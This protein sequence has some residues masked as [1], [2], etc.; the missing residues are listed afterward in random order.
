VLEW[1]TRLTND[2]QG[3]GADLEGGGLVLLAGD[4][5]AEEH[6][7]AEA[8]DETGTILARTHLPDGLAGM[9]AFQELLGRNA[10]PRWPTRTR[11]RLPVGVRARVYH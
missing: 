9:A 6:Y 7:D 8:Q 2:G 4:D 5:W 10:P 11:M 1:A 3:A